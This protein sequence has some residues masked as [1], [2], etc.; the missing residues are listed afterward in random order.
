MHSDKYLLKNYS[1]HD[2]CQTYQWEE[3]NQIRII[4]RKPDSP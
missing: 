1:E 3:I 4:N 2:S